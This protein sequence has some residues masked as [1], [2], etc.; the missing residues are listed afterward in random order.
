VFEQYLEEKEWLINKGIQ[1]LLK[2][3]GAFALVAHFLGSLFFLLARTEAANGN[4]K[5][6]ATE[7]GILNIQELGE[8]GWDVSL[9]SEVGGVYI[10]YVRAT[11]WAVITMV[12]TGYGDIVPHNTCETVFCMCTMYVG[13]LF[14]CSIIGNLTNLVANL[15][16]AED[17][18][19]Q[20][21]DN[22]NKYMA[23]RQLPA[24]LRSKVRNY[25]TYVYSQFKGFDETSFLSELPPA[26]RMQVTGLITTD[27]LKTVSFLRAGSPPLLNAL[28]LVME[29]LIF[30][31]SDI[32]VKRGEPC[33]G[34]LFL[35]RGETDKLNKDESGVVEKLTDRDRLAFGAV[36]LLLQQ[37]TTPFTIRAKS[38][39][40][41]HFLGRDK[42]QKVSKKHS[43]AE[44]M[45]KMKVQAE[46]LAKCEAK[47]GKFFGA[48]Q[49]T[50]KE[51]RFEF[52][53]QCLLP[54][55]RFRRLWLIMSSF[56]VLHYS[57]FVPLQCGFCY[58]HPPGTGFANVCL[59]INC[60]VDIFFMVDI[61]F[62]AKYFVFE[63]SGLLIKDPKLIYE[64]YRSSRSCGFDIISALPL[65]LFFLPLGE[66]WLP[67]LRVHKL[68]RLARTQQYVSVIEKVSSVNTSTRRLIKL[69]F[70]VG[71]AV[72][73]V[74]CG[75]YFTAKHHRYTA[76]GGSSADWAMADWIWYDTRSSGNQVYLDH[77]AGN[78]IGGYLRAIY[79][80][81]VS[82]TTVGYGDIVP[83][84]SLE[85][86]FA[87]VVVLVG[88]LAYPAVVGAM[89]V[90]MGTID[91]ARMQFKTKMSDLSKYMQY[92]GFPPQLQDRITRYHDYIWTRQHGVDEDQILEELP[93][94][95]RTQ[96]IACTNHDTV[97][98]IPFFADCAKDF[99]KHLLS[100]LKPVTFLP[101]D[102]V[103]RAG[104]AGQEMYFIEH[105]ATAVMSA[106][107]RMT[108]AVLS[109]G[110]YF[111]EACLLKAEKRSAT[112][113]AL[114]YCDCLIL[115]RKKFGLVL[116]QYPDSTGQNDV[117]I[118]L[119]HTLEQKKNQNQKV[120]LNLSRYPK[121][122][123]TT[124]FD[125]NTTA[126][127]S[128][129][130]MRFPGSKRRQLW[131]VICLLVVAYNLLAIPFRLAFSSN[132]ETFFPDYIGDVILVAD[133]VLHW[134]WFGYLHEGSVFTERDDIKSHYLSSANFNFDLCT[135]IP[136]EV[137]LVFAFVTDRMDVPST[138][139]ICRLPKLAKL[140]HL[141]TYLHDVERLAAWMRIPEVHIK[142]LKLLAAVVV[143]AHWLACMFFFLAKTQDHAEACAQAAATGTIDAV[144]CGFR[145]TWVEHQL[146]EG[147]LSVADLQNDWAMYLRAVNWSLP[148][149]VVV[150]IGDVIPVN[151]IETMYVFFVIVVGI[152]VNAAIIGNIANLVANLEGSAATFSRDMD[153]LDKYM[154]AVSLPQAIRDRALRY[155][156]YSWTTHKG[157]D[158]ASITNSFPITLRMDTS[159]FL[160]LKHIQSCPLF[161][162]C[163]VALQK[164]LA[165]SLQSRVYS[166]AD[167]IVN[168]DDVADQMFF[169]D[170]GT[171]QI[172]A[173]AARSDEF[174]KK[175]NF[176]VLS[177]LTE[178]SYFGEAP[179]LHATRC[180]ATF[181]AQD[182][183]ELFV[184]AKC[185]V[186]NLL[187]KYPAQRDEIQEMI[188]D[189]NDELERDIN[190]LKDNLLLHSNKQSKLSK[191]FDF[192]NNGEDQLAKQQ[193][194]DMFA[195]RSIFRRWWNI[196]RLCGM[197]FLAVRIPF[198][199]AFNSLDPQHLP[200]L[201]CPTNPAFILHIAADYL[202]DMFFICDI[203][204]RSTCFAYLDKGQIMRQHL[205]YQYRASGQFYTDILASFPFDLIVAWGAHP[206]PC[207][208]SSLWRIPHLLRLT[209]LSK[210]CRE[211]QDACIQVLRLRLDS[212]LL[213]IAKVLFF[214]LLVRTPLF[215]ICVRIQQIDCRK[216][217]LQSIF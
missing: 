21:M 141:R 73:W 124:C 142:L 151:N 92:K 5:N 196:G 117:L 119:R 79:W 202:V 216:N 32:V 204:L 148:T 65:D 51:S 37:Y 89:A 23:Y 98:R 208:L 66:V 26:L 181:R 27:L 86:I 199:A 38:Y 83:V 120:A 146:T 133:I 69:F 112:I 36:S 104:E 178:G 189:L 197:V 177:T 71:I 64:E 122:M 110:D 46:S 179:L 90:L 129:D 77:S 14:T 74:G 2:L 115:S 101:D 111:G 140:V 215:L 97:S 30:S 190:N 67:F 130:S 188:C 82:M 52:I 171:V 80:A 185:D 54:D 40:E 201:H 214:T 78:G 61:V 144:A 12:T 48:M 138:M 25:W 109:N 169:V 116:E 62:H 99:L 28:A 135:A 39:C 42:F 160:K 100:V 72:H 76:R 19:Q 22:F 128:S 212:G 84:N 13:V 149:L 33:T 123:Q 29:Q 91:A 153:E 205:W 3:Y 59:A 210:C 35:S 58:D 10:Q 95:L 7:D 184:L 168:E 8:G 132:P 108:Y 195:P 211:V 113:R 94:T 147:L 118:K 75:W 183:C 137:C 55:S 158:D 63:K 136:F 96:I 217:I 11:Y 85:S 41:F 127:V 126:T 47:A 207:Y 24:K 81:I 180:L 186:E 103:I 121:L 182:Y 87:S 164:A 172:G 139:A 106:D 53:N 143:T 43:S 114:S 17:A 159:N 44:A 1:R 50:V 163:D 194:C 187:G 49:N 9:P 154:R 152:T 191:L 107:G 174:R 145:G 4:R 167:Y 150:V 57:V 70:I 102:Y 155:C 206:T 45:S 175:E 166:P 60:L 15:D 192:W 193:E 20:R 125:H 162:F 213:Q 93:F 131:G 16:A 156:E 6:W 105:G 157:F 170:K 209:R 161:D 18:Y 198:A 165:Y 34:A 173:H 88:G 176:I 68:C 56:G 203:I 134:W 31:P 200:E